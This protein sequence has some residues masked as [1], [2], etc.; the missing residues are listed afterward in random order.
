[1]RIAVLA[2]ALVMSSTLA[3]FADIVPTE[4]DKAASPEAR[5]VQDRLESIGCGPTEASVIV[6]T[7]DAD[8]VRYFATS[9]NTTLL[10]GALLPEEWLGAAL[11]FYATVPYIERNLRKYIVNESF[12]GNEFFDWKPFRF[13]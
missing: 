2:M 13:D 12:V 6:G 1:M 9:G 7:L 4:P 5:Q 3:A 11:W 10:A 8:Q